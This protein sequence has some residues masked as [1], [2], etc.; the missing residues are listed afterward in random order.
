[1]H[2]VHPHLQRRGSFGQ[3]IS[4]DLDADQ[5][6]RPL[7]ERARW[8]VRHAHRSGD[9]HVALIRSR[10]R[11]RHSVAPS[12]TAVREAARRLAGSSGSQPHV[13]LE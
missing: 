11:G 5:F 10:S 3:V 2:V 12:V 1:M 8:A 4:S 6:H 13:T 7:V 9:D